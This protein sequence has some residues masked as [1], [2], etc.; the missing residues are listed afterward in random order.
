MPRRDGRIAFVPLDGVSDASLVLP[1]IAG[2]MGVATNPA[3]ARRVA[4]RGARARTEHARPRHR[5]ARARGRPRPHRSPRP[6]AR[7]HDPRDEPD[8]DRRPAR[9]RRLGRAAAGPGGG[10]GGPRGPPRQPRRR[11][12]PRPGAPSAAPR[13]SPRRPTP[14]SPRRSAAVST[15]SRWPSSSP[16]PPSGCSRRTSSSTSSRTGSSDD[17]PPTRRRRDG[18][19]G[20]ARQR[21]LRAAMDWSIGLLPEPVLRLY[22]RVSVISGTFGVPTADVDPRGRRAAR[23]RAARHRRRRP[24]SSSSPR[25]RC[26]ATRTTGRAF[27]MLTTVRAD[28]Q[29]RLARSGEAVAMRWAHAYQ[30][31]AVAEEAE[32]ALPDGPRRRGA[33][34]ARRGARRHPRGARVGDGAGRRDVR[35]PAVR[36]RS[37]SSG[38]RAAT[39]RRAACGSRR[40]C[41]WPSTRRRAYRRK[42]LSGA[43]LLASYQGDYRLGE[44][45][46]REALAVAREEGDEEAMAIGPQLARHQRL[47]RRRP[48]RGRGVRVREPRDPAQDRRARRGSRSRST[49]S[50]A[51]TTSAA[52]STAPARCS[53]RAWRSRRA[54]GNANGDRRL[55]RPTSGLVERDAGRPEAA[56][57]AFAEAIE[58]WE[59]TGDRQRVSVGLHNAALLDLDR[60]PPRR[61]GGR[62]WREPTT[63]P[64]TSAT[65]P[66]WPTRWRTSCAS[67]W[68]AATSTAAAAALAASLPRAAAIGRADHRAARARGRRPASPPRAATT[69][70][71]S[72][73]GPPPA[74]ERAATGFANMPADERLRRRAGCPEARERLDPQAVADAWAEGGGPDARRGRR[75]GDGAGHP[76]GRRPA[77]ATLRPGV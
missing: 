47:R 72:A 43:G 12:V 41:R 42:A 14:R 18:A 25:P 2:A 28:A 5:R 6:D 32:R 30:V 34:P 55:A 40:R 57:D 49:R 21:S 70:S 50:A 19:P 51:S 3:A 73:C 68:S 13:S 24:A 39:T 37:P 15:A 17:G 46:L 62:G 9:A 29:D 67:T 54:I 77:D 65:G 35:A 63:S 11:A 74:A 16:R 75:G 20:P 52:I 69:S 66:R 71:R 64:A 27:A 45:Y 44:A 59:R 56:A 61:G 53:S 58:I 48:R 1:A 38:G 22:R 31:L 36:A 8:R 7:A 10:R 60:G 33:R 76:R 23:P 4:R 26:S